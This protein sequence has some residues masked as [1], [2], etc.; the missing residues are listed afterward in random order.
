VR[1]P[2]ALAPLTVVPGLLA[3]L[4]AADRGLEP[5]REPRPEPLG[6]TESAALLVGVSRYRA[7]PWQPLPD[8]AEDALVVRDAL[9]RHGFET[10]VV[11][12]D[13]PQ[14]F[15][16]DPSVTVEPQLTGARL[17]EIVKD[18]LLCSG[19]RPCRPHDEASR[20]LVW[21]GGHGATVGGEGF[22]LGMDA[23]G[24]A[25]PELPRRGVHIRELGNWLR[26]SS[27]RHVLVVI[28]SCFAGTV[29]EPRYAV[30]P[31]D[32]TEHMIGHPVRQFITSGGSR[33]Q[34]PAES[35]FRRLFVGALSGEPAWANANDD[36]W[37]TASELGLYLATRVQGLRHGQQTPQFGELLDPRFDKG[38]FLFEW[39]GRGGGPI[40]ARP[41]IQPETVVTFRDCEECP[42]LVRLPSADGLAIGVYEVT[43]AE[44]DRCTEA[45]RCRRADDAAWGR[46]RHPVIDVSLHD[47]QAF[48]AW[49]TDRT[50][51]RYR[52][53]TDAEWELAA[54]SGRPTDYW[55]GDRMERGRA[56][57]SDCGSARSRGT[58]PVGSFGFDRAVPCPER[59]GGEN[60][61]GLHDVHGNVWEWT[62][63]AAGAAPCSGT[64][65]PARA[66]VRGGSWANGARYA[67]A[68]SRVD[69]DPTLRSAAVGF[70]VVREAGAARRGP[71]GAP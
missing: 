56:H 13:L 7:A 6:Y 59:A 40:P 71:G 22:L 67:K 23:P 21:F 66:A 47:A 42:A 36:A 57:C 39:S 69:V 8:A 12:D 48:L 17:S 43:F 9:R 25:D 61:F 51:S 19:A 45:G 46:G 63:E 24:E 53:P 65:Q 10:R 20:V 26:L 54:R 33:E 29:F 27:A 2:V 70:R 5:Q 41:L 44:W 3:L 49:L 68:S 18:F 58:V 38:N 1:R 52:L 31:S 37:L 14:G 50:G 34:V 11:V 30:R 64:A 60:C 15:A 32:T 16:P 28:D 62:C 35:V 55:F 4:V